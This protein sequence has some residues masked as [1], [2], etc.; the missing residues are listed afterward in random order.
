MVSWAWYKF[1][2]G[3]KIKKGDSVSIISGKDRG[4][5]GKVLKVFP[6]DGKILVEGIFLKKKRQRPKKSGQKGEVISIASPI[7]VSNAMLF[8]KHCKKGV[9]VGFKISGDKKL[10]VCKKCENEI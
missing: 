8:C 1:C 10:R 4:K 3:V 6:V 5:S 7:S 9:R 2:N